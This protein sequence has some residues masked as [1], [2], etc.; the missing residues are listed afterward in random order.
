MYLWQ[1]G[2]E[3]SIFR[4]KR[5]V[6]RPAAYS[7]DTRTVL[8]PTWFTIHSNATSW[9]NIDEVWLSS[10]Y[11]LIFERVWKLHRDKK[12]KKI[13]RSGALVSG[14]WSWT[15]ACSAFVCR[16][17]WT[18][19]RLSGDTWFC[20]FKALIEALE[21]HVTAALCLRLAEGALLTGAELQRRL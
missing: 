16:W 5:S 19:R 1:Y 18:V 2:S 11:W 9:S 14:S 4:H 21:Q 12:K 15:S 3:L 7:L 20:F 17:W 13:T 6:N 10:A 8:T